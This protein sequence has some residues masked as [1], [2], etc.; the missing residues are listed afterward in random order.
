MLMSDVVNMIGNGN[1]SRIPNTPTK[2]SNVK[3]SFWQPGH[4]IFSTDTFNTALSKDSEIKMTLSI[5][6]CQPAENIA[7]TLSSLA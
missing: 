5:A 6:I 3:R 7:S 4:R 1:S 2:M